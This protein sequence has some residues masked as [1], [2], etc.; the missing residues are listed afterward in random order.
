MNFSKS[1]KVEVIEYAKSLEAE[2]KSLESKPGELKKLKSEFKNQTVKASKAS[3][4]LSTKER[5]LEAADNRINNLE[6]DLKSLGKASS[7]LYEKLKSSEDLYKKAKKEVVE[8]K[9]DISDLQSSISIKNDTLDTFRIRSREALNN[10]RMIKDLNSSF[11]LRLY[12]LLVR[13]PE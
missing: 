3:H 2:L 5:D 12:H 4:L 10:K 8:L 11:K 9:K 13:I 1:K 7:S 6:A